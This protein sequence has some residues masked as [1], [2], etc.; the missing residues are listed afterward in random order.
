[1]RRA[2]RYRSN[3]LRLVRPSP[4]P[5]QEALLCDL[6]LAR[7]VMH[8]E[9]AQETLAVRQTVTHLR[10]VVPTVRAACEV[11]PG[12]ACGCGCRLSVAD[13]KCEVCLKGAGE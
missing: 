11:L 7:A 6:V 5:Q 3:P 1:M 4:D 9:R 8:V 2:I 13:G 12:Q 10:P